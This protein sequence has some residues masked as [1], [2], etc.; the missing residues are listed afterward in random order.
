VWADRG[1]RTDA[2]DRNEADPS[3]R[4]AATGGSALIPELVGA[5]L[6]ALLGTLVPDAVAGLVGAAGT[7]LVGDAFA[8]GRE[9]A[10][11]ATINDL[12][13]AVDAGF[14]EH[15]TTVARRLDRLYARLE[16][17]AREGD[18]QWWRVNGAAFAARPDSRGHWLTLLE[19]SRALR[20]S[21]RELVTTWDE[22]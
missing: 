18:E 14:A 12:Q 19:E 20:R 21:V 4:S 3:K 2:A 10:L 11:D 9:Q 17:R 5:G 8:R 15:L 16:A 13:R 7:A 6:Q 22:V 1:S